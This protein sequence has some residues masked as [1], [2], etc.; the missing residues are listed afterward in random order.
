M[1]FA[2]YTFMAAWMLLVATLLFA[3]RNWLAGLMLLV[4]AIFYGSSAI[5]S[6]TRP[7]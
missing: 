1:R 7:A 2:A 6:M 3:Q 4:S 5:W